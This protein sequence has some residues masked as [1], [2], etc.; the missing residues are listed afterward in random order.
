MTGLLANVLLAVMFT[1][2]ADGPYAWAG[3]AND[4]VSV[5]ATLAMIPVAVALLAVCGN[6][7]GLGAITSLA[8]VA[9]IAIP[10]TSLL[11]VLGLMPFAMQTDI[12]YAGLICIFGWV[13]AAS[14]AGRGGW[15]AAPPGRQLRPGTR[16]GRPGRGSAPRGIGADPGSLAEPGHYLCRRIADRHPSGAL[17]GL[18]DR[19]VLPAARPPG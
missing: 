2:P 7:P 15:S 13:F 9:M 5:V 1:T 18:A 3:P 6:G 11:L 10:A 16:R 8:I 4:T 14:R 12:S 19:P 17:P